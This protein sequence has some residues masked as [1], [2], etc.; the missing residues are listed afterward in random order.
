M[1]KALFVG[2][3]HLSSHSIGSRKDDYAETCLT[4]LTFVLRTAI[5]QKCNAI[6]MPGDLF[7]DK[8]ES[9]ISRSL[10]AAL[11]NFLDFCAKSG[12][13]V[14]TVPGNHDM[15]FHNP[16][17]SKRPFGLLA[18]AKDN[19]KLVSTEPYIYKD[20]EISVGVT[21]SPF[22]FNGDKGDIK[23]RKQYFPNRL[24]VDYQIHITHGAQVPYSTSG[25]FKFMDFTSSE[26][27]ISA[28]PA[29]DLNF[30]GH[31]HWIGEENLLMRFGKKAILNPGS[32]TRGSLKMENI[33]RNIF[34]YTL[35]LHKIIGEVVPKFERIEV[36]HQKAEDVF[37]VNA[38]LGEK[39]IDKKIAEFIEQLKECTLSEKSSNT[40]IEKLIEESKVS[41]EV[42]KK[43]KEFLEKLS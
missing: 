43:A 18:R 33:K 31:I 37:D 39:Q 4:K 30:N 9:K 40:N 35:E 13:V 23:E 42:K 20:S 25:D 12:I 2:D 3:P 38:Y 6:L 24:S 41:P 27:I 32:L 29:W 8:E 7:H 11:Y 16:D 22:T 21:G 15:L 34:V 19:F 14:L 28:N 5:A 36:P 1:F 10:D 17:V 26:D